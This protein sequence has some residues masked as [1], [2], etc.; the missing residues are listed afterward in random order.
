MSN[1]YNGPIITETQRRDIFRPKKRDKRYPKC[2]RFRF[3]FYFI[4]LGHHFA[5]VSFIIISLLRLRD[6]ANTNMVPYETNPCLK[7][8]CQYFQLFISL[9]T[10]INIYV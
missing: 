9:L 7:N 5:K 10:N 6:K 1:K 8:D 2:F 4:V 3:T